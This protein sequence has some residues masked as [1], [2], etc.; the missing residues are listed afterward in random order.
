MS[1]RGVNPRTH[2][3]EKGILFPFMI[4]ITNANYDQYLGEIDSNL[5]L[6]E[7]FNM[8]QPVGTPGATITLNVEETDGPNVYPRILVLQIGVPVPVQGYRI[9]SAG[10][11][12]TATIN[13]WVGK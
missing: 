4:T 5:G 8:I 7:V 2:S 6:R 11:T 1:T 3:T 10:S 13:L 9:L 12:G